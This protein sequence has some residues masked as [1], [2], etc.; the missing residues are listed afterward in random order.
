MV[1]LLIFTKSYYPQWQAPPNWLVPQL[2]YSEELLGGHGG[3][4]QLD[5]DFVYHVRDPF[6]WRSGSDFYERPTATALHYIL[7]TSDQD[8]RYV[9]VQLVEYKA[10]QAAI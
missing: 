8:L 7:M 1:S 5:V 9:G 6:V 10:G 2:R 4:G 3:P